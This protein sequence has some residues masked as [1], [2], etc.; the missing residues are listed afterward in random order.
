MRIGANG[1]IKKNVLDNI[2][3]LCNSQKHAIKLFIDF[4]TMTSEA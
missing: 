1:S 4:T 3:W 2:Y